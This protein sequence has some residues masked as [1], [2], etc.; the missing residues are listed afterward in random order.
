M[1]KNA[2][3]MELTFSSSLSYGLF[4]YSKIKLY[5]FNELKGIWAERVKSRG[6]W[7]VNSKNSLLRGGLKFS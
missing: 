4:I 1:R 3:S 6:T 7:S 2:F 5:F